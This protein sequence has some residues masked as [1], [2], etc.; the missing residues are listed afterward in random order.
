MRTFCYDEQDGVKFITE[1]EII[2]RY[3]ETW[4]EMMRRANK[5]E[6]E[7]TRANCIDDW[8]LIHW[9]WEYGKECEG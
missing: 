8:C 1:E 9:A 2:Q 4:S 3:W 7:I 5:H 6:G